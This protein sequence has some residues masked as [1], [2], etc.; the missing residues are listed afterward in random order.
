MS[1]NA[2]FSKLFGR[3][4]IGNIQEHM[5]VAADCAH[6]LK[7]F[8]E[9]VMSDDW[10]QALTIA[11]K[12]AE[13]EE[14][15]DDIKREIRLNLP[16]SLFMPVSRSDLLELLRMQDRVPNLAKDIAGLMV[17]RQMK[18]PEALR[19]EFREYVSHSVRATEQAKRVLSEFDELVETGFSGRETEL[20]EETIKKLDEVEHETD[21]IQIQVRSKLFAMEKELDPVDVMFLYRLIEWVGDLSDFSQTVGNRMM[22]LIA[23]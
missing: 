5:N 23:R 13:L 15:A 11:G 6:E 17:G 20:I 12:V 21:L 9:A 1:S 22:Y 7:G 4:P 19:E 2:F 16:R 8:F 3:S 10:D 14:K 18:I